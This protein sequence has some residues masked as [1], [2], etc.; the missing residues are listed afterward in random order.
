MAFDIIEDIEILN[1]TVSELWLP[2]LL[3]DI[4]SQPGNFVDAGK[5]HKYM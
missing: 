2:Y 1:P 4:E 3:I 5:L